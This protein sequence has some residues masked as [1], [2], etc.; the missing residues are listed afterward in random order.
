M[1]VYDPQDVA[2]MQIALAEARA[3]QAEGEVPVG[4]VVA[5][6]GNIIA[7][8]HNRPIALCD[9]TAH[10]E[11]LAMRA[12]GT[13]LNTYRLVGATVYVTLE[14]CTMCVGAMV[15]ARVARLMFGARDPK[16][17]AAGSVYDIGRDGRLNHQIEIY[18]GLEEARCAELLTRFFTKRRG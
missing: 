17:G 1:P 2:L 16:A 6:D 4:A 13:A 14:P 11:M 8:G 18:S 3:A 7:R 9:P 12:A 15:N 5:V 10:A